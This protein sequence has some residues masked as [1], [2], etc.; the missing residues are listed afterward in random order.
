MKKNN[1]R[2][3]LVVDDDESHRTMLKAVLAS[4]GYEIFEA[5]DG[6]A[7][8]KQVEGMFFDLILM[9]LRMVQMGGIEALKVIK[10]LS[11][12]IP[13]LLMT[14]Y[15][16]VKTAVEAMKEGAYDYLTKPLDIEELKQAITKAIEHAELKVENVRL[17]EVIGSRFDFSEIIG[18][19]AKI[20]AVLET[21]SLVAPTEATVLIVGESGT[22]K[23]IVASA[24]HRNS[25]RRSGPFIK[26]NCAA[27]SETLLESELFGH[28]RG[29]FTGAVE[30][31]RG[32][33]ELAHGGTIFLDEVG[34]LSPA[35]QAKLLRVLQEREFERVG[36]SQT[37]SVDVR[38]VAA[39]NKLLNE[40]V[41]GGRFR[42]DLYYRLNVFPIHLPPLRDHREDIPLL[43]DHFLALYREKN[44]RQ[45]RGL[46]P[47]ALDLLMR[48]SWPGN[49]RELENSV[50]RAVILARGEFIT[51]EE[52]P[53]HIQS[54]LPEEREEETKPTLK[55]GFT[56]KEAERELILKVLE[57]TASNRTQAAEIL[58]ISRATLYNKLKEYGLL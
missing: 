44:H 8:V 53:L 23:E 21:V 41:K 19:S 22:G 45:I 15:A 16:S 2:K 7:A 27:L 55:S 40:E 18:K 35:T 17:K 58:G 49:V 14:A 32:R 24:V 13:I 43:A 56:I 38:V 6:S 39:T 51:P 20:R 25:E 50:E 57:E 10:T 31:R 9:D 4:E 11:P 3:I 28:E 47:R 26:M 34:D 36:G 5:H 42:E 48:Y 46:T 37:I 12:G 1:A 29:A 54:L 30:R 52:L 33:F